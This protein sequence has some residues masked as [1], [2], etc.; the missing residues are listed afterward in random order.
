ML[1]GDSPPRRVNHR[2]GLPAVRAA[3]PASDELSEPCMHDRQAGVHSVWLENL[4]GFFNSFFMSDWMH[5][6]LLLELPRIS[7]LAE[8]KKALRRRPT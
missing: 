5:R 7:V 1:S 6:V 2:T 8:S 3:S 4:D